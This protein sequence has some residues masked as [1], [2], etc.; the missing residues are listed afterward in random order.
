[1]QGNKQSK[2]KIEE[3]PTTYYYLPH[4]ELA[5]H[6]SHQTFYFVRLPSSGGPEENGLA[7]GR[8]DH[9]GIAFSKTQLP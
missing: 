8:M 7:Y 2:G 1:M 5:F 9:L 4:H 6:L 3:R